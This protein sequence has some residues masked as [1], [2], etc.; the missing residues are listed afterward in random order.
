[1]KRLDRRPLSVEFGLFEHRRPPPA[2]DTK[3]TKVATRRALPTFGSIL[4]AR[5]GGG[6]SGKCLTPRLGLNKEAPHAALQ[7]SNSKVNAPQLIAADEG[8]SALP[9]L[10]LPN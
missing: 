4:T 6:T 2:G 10:D 8:P 1:M 5:V 7:L 9:S 3:P